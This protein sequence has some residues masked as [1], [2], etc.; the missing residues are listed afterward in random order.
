MKL[1]DRSPGVLYKLG[2]A[3]MLAGHPGEAADALT[4]AVSLDNRQ[5]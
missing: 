3:Q 1:D 2:L 5:T 4:R